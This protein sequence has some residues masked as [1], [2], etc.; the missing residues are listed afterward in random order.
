MKVREID[1]FYRKMGSRG[2]KWCILNAPGTEIPLGNL[3]C[4]L[5]I[6]FS[7]LSR[8]D[9]F[10]EKVALCWALCEELSMSESQ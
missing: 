1:I 9:N 5:F 4:I 3:T 10:S 6:Y 7:D 2:C 8:Q